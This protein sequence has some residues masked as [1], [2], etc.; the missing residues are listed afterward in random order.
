VISEASRRNWSSRSA[1]MTSTWWSR[2]PVRLA[3]TA[4]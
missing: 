4:R 1:A 3:T 2:H